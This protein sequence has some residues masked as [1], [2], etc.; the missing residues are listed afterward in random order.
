M[1]YTCN[2]ERFNGDLPPTL[3]LPPLIPPSLAPTATPNNLPKRD[4]SDTGG[5]RTTKAK[6]IKM[7]HCY[8]LLKETLKPVLQHHNKVIRIQAI[9]LAAGCEA[10][11][12][13]SKPSICIKS[14]IFCTCFDNFKRSHVEITDAEA[15]NAINLLKPALDNP[16]SIKVTK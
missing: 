5:D 3:Y 6:I 1:Q 10:S 15:L 13:F 9:C 14:K 12:L 11:H 7:Q 2:W 16:A 4:H 8:P